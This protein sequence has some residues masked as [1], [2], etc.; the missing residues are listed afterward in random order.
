M[1]RYLAVIA[2]AGLVMAAVLFDPSLSVAKPEYSR[3]TKKECTYCHPPNSWDINEAGR[4]FR[5]HRHSLEGFK[6]SE[7]S[8]K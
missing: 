2:P 1:G 4:Y 6:P 7:G 8:G 3:R 5:D